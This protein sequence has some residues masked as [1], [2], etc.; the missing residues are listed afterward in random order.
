MV[1]VRHVET[2]LNKNRRILGQG[3]E[4]ANETGLA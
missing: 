4:P 2:D 3:P 1:L